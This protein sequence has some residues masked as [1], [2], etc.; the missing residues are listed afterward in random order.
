MHRYYFH[1]K[2]AFGWYFEVKATNMADAKEQA[3]QMAGIATFR[4]WEYF[5][6]D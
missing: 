5:R 3:K 4:G 1:N 2:R 6:I